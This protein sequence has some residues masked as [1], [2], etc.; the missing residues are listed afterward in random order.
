MSRALKIIPGGLMFLLI[1][2]CSKTTDRRRIL[3]D[4]EEARK[5]KRQEDSI[6]RGQERRRIPSSTYDL[7]PVNADTLIASTR[8]NG[9]IITT[10]A[11]ATWT[12]I[13]DPGIISRL[14]IDNN[15]TIWGLYSW[16]G[17]HEA[18]KSILY[19]ST[20]LGRTWRKYELETKTIFP[21]DFYSKPLQ[22]LRLI[23]YDYRIYELADSRSE[24]TWSS[25]DSLKERMDISPWRRKK[26]V[27]DSKNRRWIFNHRG[28]FLISH[29]T[30]KV[31]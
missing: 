9:I 10:N 18:D 6:Y 21:G 29:D 28:I 2:S 25:V 17:I 5:L 7:L 11:G 19:S 31:Y 26:Y 4:S 20:D 15:K 27:L 12:S 23:D 3:S 13:S 24:L 14:T 8:F 1:V 30:I 16:Q 22:Q